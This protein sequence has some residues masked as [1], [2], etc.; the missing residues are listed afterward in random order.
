MCIAAAAVFWQPLRA[1]WGLTRLAV[2]VDRARVL[3]NDP[4]FGR[5]L[6][7]PQS[8]VIAGMFGDRDARSRERL[9]NDIVKL[10]TPLDGDAAA[11]AMG[12]TGYA[13]GD[14][15][16]A[17]AAFASVH[18]RDARDWSDLTAAQICVAQDEKRANLWL[19][20]LVS[21]DRA[22]EVDPQRP[23]ARFNRA[24]IVEA[25]G[26]RMHATAQWERFLA[27]DGESQ[28]AELARSRRTPEPVSDMDAWRDVHPKVETMSRD[29]LV[30]LT[31]SRPEPARRYAEMIYLAT[32]ADR[33][34]AGDEDGARRM[35]D[36][37]AVIAETL[38]RETGERLLA[39]SLRRIDAAPSMRL[40]NGFLAYRDGRMVLD[41][42]TE[43]AAAKLQ[44]AEEWLT[45]EH[46]PLANMAAFHLADALAQQ[47]R[48]D[49]SMAILD[50]LQSTDASYKAL[51]A[52]VQYERSLGEAVRGNWSVSLAAAGESLARFTAIGERQNAVAAY[53]VLAENYELIGQRD[54]ALEQGVAGLRATSDA[55]DYDRMHATLAVLCRAELRAG[56]NARALSL[57]T[58][59]LEI[60]SLWSEVRH[61]ADLRLRRATAQWRVGKLADALQSL[62]QAR[63]IARQSKDR[64]QRAKLLADIDATE[65]A[66]IRSREPQRALTLLTSSIDFQRAAERPIILPELYLQ[67]GRAHLALHDLGAAERDFEAGLAELE[68]QRSR[69]HNAEVRPGI[70]DDATELFDEAIALQIRL[71]ADADAVLRQVERGR[72]RAVFEQISVVDDPVDPTFIPRIADIQRVLDANTALI[73][74]VSLPQQLVV[75]IVRGE[76]SV[77][78]TLP[79]TRKQ[80][81]DES[82]AF[83]ERK[84]A[85]GAALY[86]LVLAPIAGDLRGVSAIN[87][88]ADDMLQ[89]VPWGALFDRRTRTFLV[90][91]HVIATSPSAAVFLATRV[92]MQR[93]S[94]KPAA[95][96]LV[97]AN[98]AIPRDRYGNLA[99]LLSAEYEGPRIAQRYADARLFTRAD[100][101]ADRFRQLAPAYDYVHFGGHGVIREREPFSSALVCAGAGVTAHDIARMN[102]RSTRAVVLAACSTMTGRSTNIEGV[103]SLS[104]AFLVAGVPAVI[105][106]LWNIEDAEASVITLPLHDGLSRGVAPADALRI[107]QL[108]AI[109]R[110]APPSQWS[111]FAL[112][113]SA[114]HTDASRP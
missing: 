56:E 100:A 37:V 98:P 62:A 109:R 88:V 43:T 73:E 96:I 49:E 78:R 21:A 84:G 5:R 10:A 41:S 104:R 92:R 29:E 36:T 46:C 69:V 60:G 57:T 79:V 14:C 94:S 80:L 89:R 105:G 27:V 61:D 39:D 55:G 63:A 111:A 22:L 67:R 81:E 75:F 99:S 103:P 40:A 52:H 8:A 76:R 50:R 74:Y 95:R 91:H 85:N 65:G 15:Q 24:V 6:S 1:R 59:E 3:A 9:A 54:L 12:V 113:G 18:T 4:R 16:G 53:P 11:R 101:T 106:T 68:R 97:F 20:A 83:L 93:F 112:M 32:W 7:A 102:F 110:G 34:A 86:D 33:F 2:A 25:L 107:A 38:A 71:G 17:A 72:A 66:L 45:A 64:V 31:K 26:L 19:T 48:F 90:Q 35:R 70:F 44:Q 13:R 30:A 114:M 58:L 23:E 42:D 51:H 77:M 82:L 28:W 108:D 47:H 87:V